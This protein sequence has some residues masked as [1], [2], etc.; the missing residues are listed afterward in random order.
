[1]DVATKTCIFKAT[2]AFPEF[3]Q[4][5]FD[6]KKREDV[7]T[8]EKKEYVS[9]AVS[10]PGMEKEK[11]LMDLAV[12]NGTGRE[13]AEA[14]YKALVAWKIVFRIVALSFD[15]CSVNTGVHEGNSAE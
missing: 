5:H 2:F 7:T 9:I 3:L 1:M 4:L 11:F 12:E 14:V 13:V 10:G 8:G 6:G 15:T